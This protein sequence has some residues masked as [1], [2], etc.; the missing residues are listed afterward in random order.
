MRKMDIRL[1]MAVMGGI[2]IGFS[3]L[4]IT[5]FPLKVVIIGVGAILLFNAWTL[6]IRL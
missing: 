6:R 2:I 3:L 5:Y 4:N 1:I